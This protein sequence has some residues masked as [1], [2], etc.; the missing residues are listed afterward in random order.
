MKAVLL[1]KKAQAHNTKYID[2]CQKNI[3]HIKNNLHAE[4]FNLKQL[5]EEQAQ[6]AAELKLLEAMNNETR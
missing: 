4:E 5:E 2:D 3:E 1:L 6:I